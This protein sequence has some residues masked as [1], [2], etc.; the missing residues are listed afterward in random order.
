[1]IS[2]TIQSL[3]NLVSCKTIRSHGGLG[4]EQHKEEYM[5][6][7]LECYS[8]QTYIQAMRQFLEIISAATPPTNEKN[9]EQYS[10]VVLKEGLVNLNC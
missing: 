5:A 8:S 10:P 9:D 6:R 3:G 1:M 7:L 2:K 4:S